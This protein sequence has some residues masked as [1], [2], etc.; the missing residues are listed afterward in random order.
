V[1]G[2]T[3]IPVDVRFI[4]ATHRDLIE[5]VEKGSFRQDLFYRLNVITIKLPSL[6]E[7]HGDIPLLTYHFLSQ[8]SKDMNKDIQ[9]ISQES[10]ELLCQY[11]WP[12]NIRELEN[13]IE[14]AVALANGPEITA[15]HLPE[16]ISNLSIETYRRD[17][18]N[19]PTLEDQEKNYIKWVLD[20]CEG[21]KT[22]A[23][24]IMGIDRVSLWRKIKRFELEPQND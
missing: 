2:E 22:Q 16:Y 9:N 10:M 4:T 1:G 7:R 15:S 12:G 21:N 17:D 13:V 3:P 23:A 18:S 5:D 24:K 6:A 8:K 19:L 11:G 14:R 20:K